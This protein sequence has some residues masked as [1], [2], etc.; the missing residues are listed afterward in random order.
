MA[1]SHVGMYTIYYFYCTLYEVVWI[2][3]RKCRDKA[4]DPLAQAS[5]SPVPSFPRLLPSRLHLGTET[6]ESSCESESHGNSSPKE[7][8]KP[9][10]GK[11]SDGESVL[12]W[13]WLQ[14]STLLPVCSA[15]TARGP[16]RRNFGI[17]SLRGAFESSSI[18]VLLFRHSGETDHLLA[19]GGPRLS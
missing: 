16:G 18:W 5:S 12:D 19:K 6:T 2:S 11:T 8:A 14:L 1:P 17:S 10:T 9:G 7:K 3:G 4:A 13:R 15:G